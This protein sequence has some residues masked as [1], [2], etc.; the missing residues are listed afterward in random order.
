[1]KRYV[2][3]MNLR[4]RKSEAGIEMVFVPGEGCVNELNEEASVILEQFTSPSTIEDMR[5]NLLNIYA[6]DDF[7]TFIKETDQ[8]ITRFLT[9]K[10]L[11]ECD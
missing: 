9:R 5:K 1:M 11:L 10:I 2:R 7:D 3:N 8:I 4:I 6:V